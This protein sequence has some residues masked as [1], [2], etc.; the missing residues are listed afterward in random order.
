M[1]K[2]EEENLLINDFSNITLNGN[3]CKINKEVKLK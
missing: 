2:L 3:E 1:E